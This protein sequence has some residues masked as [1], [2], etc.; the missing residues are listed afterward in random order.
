MNREVGLRAQ[1]PLVT[2]VSPRKI[3]ILCHG[4]PSLSKG[5]SEIAAYTLFK[6]LLALGVD[7]IF[8][9][10]CAEADRGRLG[11]E[12][13]RE[14]AVFHDPLIYDHFYHLASP[15][16]TA[17]ILEIL[18]AE[19]VD[20]VNFHHFYILGS[21][22]L[23]ATAELGLP[24][25]VTLHEFLAI[26]HHNGQMITRP[27]R[28]L[29]ETASPQACFGCFPDYTR[30]Q[31]A[32]RNAYFQEV[33]S[34]VHQFV[35]PS[36]FLVERFV[37]WGLD[38]DRV[39]VI[40]NGLAHLSP[41]KPRPPRGADGSWIFGFFGQINSFKGVDTILR[42]AEQIAR[43]N[44]LAGRIRIHL[45]GNITGQSEK[46]FAWLEAALEKY[47]FVSYKGAY[48]NAAVGRLMSACDYV[49]VPSTWWENSP[50]VIQEAYAAGRPVLC[51]GVGGM[52]EKVIEGVSGL[53]FERG[54][55]ADLV[56]AMTRAAN[57]EVFA[58]LCKGLPK[59]MSAID[60]AEAYLKVYAGAKVSQA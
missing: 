40:E 16:V 52:A 47:N 45:H 13:P 44:E 36:K 58:Q 51:T 42:A 57:P 50:M 59:V 56:R 41:L 12:S 55:D 48:E 43:N 37:K 14:H 29:C 32:L 17:A 27:A 25:I 35:S 33:F 49:L 8:I 24:T 30:Q 5:G 4:H 60:M 28:M 18:V 9:A 3:A 7:V 19:R 22:A 46:F 26:C 10:A 53:H 31:F 39:T 23:R 2:S 34:G 11:L 54:D 20:V 21:N 15:A 6:G 1:T 38:E